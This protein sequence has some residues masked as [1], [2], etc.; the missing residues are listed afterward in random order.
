MKNYLL[1]VLFIALFTISN[2]SI[3]QTVLWLFPQVHYQDN[4]ENTS[5][6]KLKTN[7]L[8]NFQIVMDDSIE[9]RVLGEPIFREFTIKNVPAGNHTF[10]VKRNYKYPFKDKYN[11]AISLQSTGNGEKILVKLPKPKY[12]NF[13][14]TTRGFALGGFAVLWALLA[15]SDSKW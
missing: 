3:A 10:I 15:N 8:I 1:L 13:I 4:S 12:N 11:Y 2:S 14:K 5:T 6:V 9:I 7:R